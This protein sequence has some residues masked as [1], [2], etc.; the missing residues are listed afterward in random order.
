V[1]G[2]PVKGRQFTQNTR[3]DLIMILK[4]FVLWMIVNKYLPN[5][6]EKKNRAIKVPR[7]APTKEASDLLSVTE[8]E[9]L[10]EACTFNRNRAMIMMLYEGAFR[11]GEIGE[12]R[13]KDL[14]IDGTGLVVH[15]TFKTEK[16]RYVRL[17]MAREHLINGNQNIPAR[18]LMM[19]LSSYLA[20]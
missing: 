3:V 4:S 16:H 19:D 18:S 20:R 1:N 9:A 2:G 15:V 12:M 6:P 7:I 10:M 17:V 11:A 13:W 5:V 14:K 8:I